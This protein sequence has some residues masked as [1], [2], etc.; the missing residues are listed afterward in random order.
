MFRD[1]GS[2]ERLPALTKLAISVWFP[3]VLGLIVLTGV[4]VGV[5]RA[6]PLARRRAF[7]VAAFLLGGGGFA[8]CLLGAYLPIFALAEAVKAE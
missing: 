8:L 3:V 5:R 2:A 4:L 1:F 6:L 7:I